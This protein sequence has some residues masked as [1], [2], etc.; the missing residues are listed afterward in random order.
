MTIPFAILLFECVIS[1]TSWT[2]AQRFTAAGQTGIVLARQLISI[3][4]VL[5]ALPFLPKEN[6]YVYLAL[7]M[8]G[9][10]CIRL[11]FTIVLNITRLKEPMPEFFPTRE[12][13]NLVLRLI[14]RPK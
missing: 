6:T 8:L 7:L 2:L 5:I 10:A 11:I 4:P 13:F 14:R 9:C 3:A 1:G 12:D